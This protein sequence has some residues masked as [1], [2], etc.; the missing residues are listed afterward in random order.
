MWKDKIKK[1][2]EVHDIYMAAW[3]SY[4]HENLLYFLVIIITQSEVIAMQEIIK[5]DYVA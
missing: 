5:H 1:L 3:P 4:S 2:I